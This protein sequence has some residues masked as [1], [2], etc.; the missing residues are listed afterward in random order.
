MM[1]MTDPTLPE[2]GGP[3]AHTSHDHETHHAC[4]HIPTYAVYTHN[5]TEKELCL[6]KVHQTIAKDPCSE[7]NAKLIT[8]KP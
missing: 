8:H 4:P 6:I 3:L 5:G 2:Q 1:C 7:L